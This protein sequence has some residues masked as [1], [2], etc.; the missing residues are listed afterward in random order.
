M[1]FILQYIFIFFLFT[2]GLSSSA[3]LITIGQE[4]NSEKI[5]NLNSNGFTLNLKVNQVEFLKIKHKSE[6]YYQAR[7]PNFGKSIDIGNPQLPLYLR[8]IEIPAHATYHVLVTKMHFKIYNLS[9]Y[10]I[11]Q[12]LFPAQESVEKRENAP[13]HFRINESTYQK[14]AFYSQSLYSIKELG[15]MR[16]THIARLSIAAVE[17]NPVKNLLKVYDELEIRV[18]FDI[19]QGIDLQTEKQQYY[20]PAF[21]Q[22]NNYLLNGSAYKAK[23]PVVGAQYPVK[24]VIVADSSFRTALIPFIKW[25]EKQGYKIIEAYTSDTAVGYTNS[26]IKNYLHSL[27]NAGTPLD[28][29]PSFVLFVGDINQIP[30]YP[31]QLGSWPADLYYCEFTN[32]YFPEMMYGRFSANDTGELNPQIEKSIEYEKY[33]MSN[34][35]YLDTS[36]LISGN[37][38]SHAST[39]GDGQ[40]NYGTSTYFN[41]TNNIY[42]KSYLYINQ[43][44][45]KDLEIRQN[46]D[47]GAA[48][49]NYTAH[50]LIP[51]WYDPRF[52]TNNVADM[53]NAGKYPIMIGNA[54]LTNKFDSPSNCFGEAL[55]RARNKGA[56]AYIGATDNTLWDEDYYWAVGYGTITSNPTYATTT[57]GLYDMIFHTHGEPHNQ[58]ALNAYEYLRAGNMAVTQG[59]S[60]VRRYWELY[61][62]MGDP[63]LMPYLKVPSPITAVY[64]PL[65]PLGVSSFDITTDAYALVAISRNDSL[66]SSTYADS[67]GLATLYFPPFTQ[68]GN[69]DLVITASQKQPYFGNLTAGSPNGPYIIYGGHQILD[70]S[71]N[72]NGQ[73][74]YNE[75]INL[76]MNLVNITSHQADSAFA[77]LR[78]DDNS[79]SIT[80][81]VFYLGDFPGNDTLSFDSVFAFDV[82]ANVED[83]HEVK[84]NVIVQDSTGAQ[85]KSHFF[86]RL[87]APKININTAGIDDHQYGN[88]NGRIDAGETVTMRV[89]L[90]NNGSLE[91]GII[92][93]NLTTSYTGVSIANTTYQM[94]T[95]WTDSG[96]VALFE[97]NIGNNFTNGDIIRFSFDY[98]TNNR[99][100]SKQISQ[101]VGFVDEDFES[102]DFS[103]FKWVNDSP[104]PW[105]I[106]DTVVFEGNYSACSGLTYDNDTS[107][108]SITLKALSDDSISFYQKVSCEETFDFLY[109]Y[110]DD[111]FQGKWSGEK[112]WT[113]E[114]FP[115]KEG[116]HTFKWA[117]VKDY[118]NTDYRDAVFVDM[119][120]FPPTD[121]WTNVK[122]A[123]Q[124]LSSIKLM[125]NPANSYSILS[126]D[127]NSNSQA[128]IFLYDSEGRQLQV[129]KQRQSLQGPQQIRINTRNLRSGVYFISI[130]SGDQ[131][132]Y[133]KLIVL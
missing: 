32:D 92:Q 55:L 88:G 68:A 60:N 10:Q 57:S 13:I 80:D 51:G 86:I 121:A 78:T 115:V 76:D 72:N 56:I 74:D 97:I 70:S 35:S 107:M 108:L 93:C 67:A 62:L 105:F 82:M 91:T 46:A 66:I 9:D 71:Q 14:D 20:S 30:K 90:E 5:S 122:D 83:R 113:R 132:W 106:Q 89:P 19:P 27:Y 12:R 18:V 102:G 53:K 38:A 37:D 50:G 45:N 120:A 8:L 126:F 54:C 6:V 96:G 129:I 15:E 34:P 41:A 49:I 109:F 130:Q 4:A 25:K 39:Y 124:E 79:I 11:N 127:L 43:S 16:G 29:A 123:Q 3:Q 98:T 77:I 63:S 22:V 94:D 47:S 128:A 58:W 28:P 1:K 44:Y 111:I 114:A 65:L 61:H 118:V 52:Y 75:H 87:G 131:R 31:G 48:F 23:V 73:A 33:L 117:Y 133:K 84:L 69:V 24:Y 2:Y 21:Q 116:I 101:L 104:H 42:C 103:K 85:W 64:S 36:I 59:G 26:S 17:Y 112:A 7:I 99:V 95:L 100:G 125:P 40:V 119:I 110:I 81:S